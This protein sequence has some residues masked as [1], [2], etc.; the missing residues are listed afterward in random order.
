MIDVRRSA[1]HHPNSFSEYSAIIT[2]GGMGTRMLPFSKEIPKEM[3][4]IITYNGRQ[5]LELKPL[6]QAIYEQLY[7]AGI[8]T[9]YVVVGRGKRAIEDHFTPDPVF[10]ALLTNRGKDPG[11]LVDFY[12][13]VKS[14]HLVFLNQPE[15]L[16]F[17]DAVLLARRYAKGSFIVQAADTIIYSERDQYL[18]RL[19]S[20]HRKYRASATILLEEVSNPRQFGVVE[21]NYLEDG[22]ILMNGAE[23]KPEAPR[24]KLAIMPVYVF[25]EEIFDALIVTRPGKGGELQLTDGIQKLIEAERT[26]IGVKLKPGELRLDLGS[27][28][29]LME[30]LKLSLMQ[31]DSMMR[32]KIPA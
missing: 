19:V 2:A 27:P 12:D 24:T 29:P 18:R 13:K 25:T 7:G 8:R 32:Y 30:A 6:V 26:V 10:S 11:C 9:F 4:P 3:F 28:E 22:V 21:G 31:V 14:S 5:C 1:L 23:E 17:G 20:M 15:P 16:G